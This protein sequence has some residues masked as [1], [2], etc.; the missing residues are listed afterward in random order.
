M[1]ALSNLKIV[2]FLAPVGRSSEVASSLSRMSLVASAMGVPARNCMVMMDEFSW[3][4]ELMCLSLS[5]PLRLFSSTFVTLDSM[6]SALAP[7]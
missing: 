5:I 3:L 6:S 4:L 7:G 2:G 1:L